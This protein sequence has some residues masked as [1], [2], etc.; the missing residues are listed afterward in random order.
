MG[1][2]SPRSTTARAASREH[3]DAVDVLEVGPQ[4]V[5]VELQALQEAV[6]GAEGKDTARGAVRP[7]IKL[8]DCLG[9]GQSKLLIISIREISEA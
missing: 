4:E 5:V 6:G 2:S 8:L 7:I 3:V 1:S 9:E